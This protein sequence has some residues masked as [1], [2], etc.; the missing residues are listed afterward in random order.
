MG[1]GCRD[2]RPNSRGGDDM[3]TNKRD[4]G[5]GRDGGGWG[6]DGCE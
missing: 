5:R 4:R 2:R 1:G 6:R 3:R